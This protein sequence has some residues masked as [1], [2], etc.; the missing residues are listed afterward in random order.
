MLFRPR[1]PLSL[2]FYTVQ[3]LVPKRQRELAASIGETVEKRL[4]PPD[5]VA[6]LM[7][8]PELAKKIKDA[9]SGEVQ[10]LVDSL[11]AKNP[12]VGMFIQ[13]E[14]KNQ[15]YAMLQG[16]LDDVIPGLLEQGGSIVAKELNFQQI[17]RERI[18]AFDLSSLEE[19]VVNLAKKELRVIEWV[20]G[21]L[22]FII[23]VTQ[24]GIFTWIHG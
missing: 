21:V 9:L 10:G 18:E 19:L 4:L 5:E 8:R 17:V 6:K 23:G 14:T 1:K 11:I 22:G 15:I 2:G 3:G 13:G 24:M 16:K 12:M 20:G 7:V